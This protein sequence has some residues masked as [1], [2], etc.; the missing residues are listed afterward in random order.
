MSTHSYTHLTP[1]AFLQRASDVFAEKTAIA[2]GERRLSYSEFGAEATGLAGALRAS[3]VQPGDRVAY[4]VPNIPEMLV[5]NFGVPLAGAVLVAVN[6]RLSAEEVRYVC[7]HSGAKVLV[8][9][10]EYLPSLVPIIE[11]LRTVQEVVAVSD[12]LGPAAHHAVDPAYTTYDEFLK[13]GSGT[14]L[15]WSV[16]D[17]NSVIS[18]NYSS[19]TTGQPKGAMYT[20]RGAYLNAL[21]E[22]IHQRFD[23]ESIYLWTLPMFHC[24]GWCTPWAVTGIGATHVCL[25]AVRADV[26]WRLFDEEGITH[27]CGAPTVLTTIAEAPEAHPLERGLVATVAGAAP[28]PTV[29]ARMRE[30]GARIVHVYGMTEV[31]GPYSLNEWQAGWAAL[32]AADQARRQAR[33]G[34]SMIQADPIRVVDEEM[35]D[36]PRDGRTMGEIVMRGNNVMKGY[37]GDEEGTEKAFKGGWLHSGDLGVQHSDGYVELRDRAKDIVISGGE[38]ISTVEIEHALLSHPAILAAAVIGVPDEKWGERPK[39]F[40]MRKPGAEANEAELIAYLQSH[41][42]RY[43]V[44]KA[45]EFVD[46]LPL[47]STGKIQKFELRE[48]EWAGHTS[49]IQG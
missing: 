7:D 4:M 34:V 42:A 10:T 15:P 21:G 43:K 48:K 37:Y 47:T 12:P 30:L 40:V 1:L 22:I 28:S 33:Q 25:R 8:V 18:I 29:I 23:A 35:N 36:V 17:E 6:T 16:E 45:V 13:R 39:A 2:Y 38:N 27:L 32:P 41:I 24:N 14:Q 9:D 11:S 20:H 31:Y 44:P 5:A 46:K 3:G 19:G 26:I 49:R